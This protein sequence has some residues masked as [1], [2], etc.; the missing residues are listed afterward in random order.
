MPGPRWDG[1]DRSNGREK[2]V[3]RF[4]ARKREEEE[5]ANDAYAMGNINK[6]GMDH[7]G[8]THD[9]AMGSVLWDRK[10]LSVAERLKAV[11]AR[12][13]DGLDEEEADEN[14]FVSYG[15]DMFGDR[16]FAEMRRW[17]RGGPGGRGGRRRR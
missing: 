12:D 4:K 10:P 5:T 1:V 16:K 13:D 6:G 9:L 8:E 11:Q 17:E 14:D 7:Y 3:I 2:E 15:R